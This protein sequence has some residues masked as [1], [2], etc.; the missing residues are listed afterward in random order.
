VKKS[1]EDIT[2]KMKTEYKADLAGFGN[3]LRIKH[4]RLWEKLKKNWDE[5][6]TDIPITFH[7]QIAIKEYGTVGDQ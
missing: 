7:V 3:E 2:K 5:T 4:P 6:F 1:M